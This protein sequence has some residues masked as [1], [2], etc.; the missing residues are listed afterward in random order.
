MKAFSSLY[1]GE[2][3]CMRGEGHHGECYAEAS[4]WYEATRHG[5][6]AMMQ[7]AID[8]MELLIKDDNADLT[9][10]N[11]RA[12]ALYYVGSK[13]CTFHAPSM[14]LPCTFLAPSM[15]LPCTFIDALTVALD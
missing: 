4:Q 9:H 14:H 7:R 10:D 15:H 13:V 5:L 6:D 8:E 11:V 3:R 1:F 2:T 12:Q